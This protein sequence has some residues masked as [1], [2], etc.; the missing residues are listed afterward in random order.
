MP[1]RRFVLLYALSIPMAA[2]DWPWVRTLIQE[3]RLAEAGTLLERAY[4]EAK[5]D[6]HVDGRLASSC[7]LLAQKHLSSATP[8]DGERCAKL[9]IEVWTGVLGPDSPRAAAAVTLLATLYEAQ[10]RG[11]EA[12]QGYERAIAM[13]ARSMG[14]SHPAVAHALS[15]AARQHRDAGRLEAAEA[16]Q[17]RA[18]AIIERLPKPSPLQRVAA[19]DYSGILTQLGRD[20]ESAL[21]RARAAAD[22]IR[23]VS[24]GG[25]QP[26][27]IVHKV[28]PDYAPEAREGHVEGKVVMTVVVDVDGALRNIAITSP[29]GAGLDEKAVEALSQW[30]FEPARDRAGAP[31]PVAATVEVNFRLL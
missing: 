10:K 11:A 1:L 6:A 16:A 22:P 19:Q 21:W 17:R 14:E 7:E 29:L 27:R 9:A 24:A 20:A 28:E 5:T 4:G 18:I 30:R 15:F 31:V 26:P 2:Q 13:L 23:L 12:E 3:G 25:Y 8:A